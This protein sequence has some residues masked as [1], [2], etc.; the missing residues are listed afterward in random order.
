MDTVELGAI[1]TTKVGSPEILRIESCIC[2]NF[3]ESLQIAFARCG[4]TVPSR[5]LE[6]FSNS[7]KFAMFPPGGLAGAKLIDGSASYASDSLD[8]P[9]KR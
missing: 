4:P 1:R 5:D 2:R 9:T 6:V 7:L 8:R 3:G